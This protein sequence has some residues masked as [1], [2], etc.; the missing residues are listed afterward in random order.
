MRKQLGSK[1]SK[2]NEGLQENNGG[3]KRRYMSA[4]ELDRETGED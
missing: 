3:V 4:G 1:N 2:S